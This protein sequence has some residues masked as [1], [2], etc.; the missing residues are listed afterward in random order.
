MYK[1]CTNTRL[2]KRLF[3][4]PMKKDARC[5]IWIRNT[6]NTKLE[7]FSPA[8]LRSAS[9]CEDHFTAKCFTNATKERLI[10]N[11][12]PIPYNDT[13]SSA[14][15]TAAFSLD[16]ENVMEVKLPKQS[17]LRTYKRANLNF[18]VTAEEENI[19]E[20]VPLE[21]SMP[22]TDDQHQDNCTQTNNKDT[23]IIKD[24]NMENRHLRQELRR[25]KFLLQRMSEKYKI[26][27]TK[28]KFSVI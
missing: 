24:L 5:E 7:K 10:R 2:S 19:M 21:P 14:N 17:A 9:L 3:R 26:S 15:Y 18:N 23:K 28:S 13:G 20:W 6:G 4:F 16:N 1:D 25:Q 22:P 12:I 27:K 8:T 11:A